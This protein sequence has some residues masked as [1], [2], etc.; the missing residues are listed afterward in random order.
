MTITSV[1]WFVA[2]AVSATTVVLLLGT[3]LRALRG[4]SRWL[5]GG[6]IVAVAAATAL[7][8][9]I[10][11]PQ[12]LAGPAPAQTAH[13][14]V[15]SPASAATGATA[16]DAGSMDA[17]VASLE[18]RL[19]AGGGGDGDWELLAK[20]YEF[21][22][23]ADAAALARAHKL[24]A[25]SVSTVTPVVG[26]A[27]GSVA[28]P[29]PVAAAVKLTAASERLLADAEAARQKRDFKSAGK[30]YGQ[31]AASRQMTA[32]AWADYADVEASLNGNALSGRPAEYLR[33][34][35]QLDPANAKALWLQGSLEHETRQYAAAVLTWNKL[36]AIMDAGSSDARLIKANIDEDVRLSG[37]GASPVPV[38]VVAGG[39]TL[40]GEVSVSAALQSR[41]KPGQTIYVVAKS[42]NSPGIPAAA[43]RLQT[44]R[45]PLAFELSDSDAMV[46]ERRLS[47]IGPVT[48]EAR[49]SQSGQANSAPGDLLG[50]TAALDPAKSGPLHIVIDQTV[51]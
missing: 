5:I 28:A 22:N 41:I 1:F 33:N 51:R 31:L 46:P 16:G 2:G 24:P 12:T 32:A 27:V 4:Q 8:L 29:L 35:L 21:L 18:A 47:A 45:W 20:S 17:V 13:A 25:A 3:Q 39:L 43:R 50:S 38:A 49:I 30:I 23:R 44:G 10:G 11:A 34:A 36:L 6:C 26:S 19:R 7:Y 40:R 42:V 15:S 14:G 48:V 37:G 9:Q